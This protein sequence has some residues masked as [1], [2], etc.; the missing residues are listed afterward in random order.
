DFFY[1]EMG[2]GGEIL[3]SNVKISTSGDA[4]FRTPASPAAI[5]ANANSRAFFIWADS[6]TM[7]GNFELFFRTLQGIFQDSDGDGLPDAFEMAF[8]LNPN[9]PSDAQGDLDG[10][11]LTNLQEFRLQTD[12]RNRDTDG[13]GLSDGDEVN[14]ILVNGVLIKTDPL[15]PDMDSDGLSD[16]DEINVYRT[17]PLLADTDGDGLS[18]GIEVELGFNPNDST[19]L[20]KLFFTTDFDATGVSG[21]ALEVSRDTGLRPSNIY[22]SAPGKTNRLFT[23]PNGTPLTGDKLGIAAFEGSNIDAI[24][25]LPDGSF[26]FSIDFDATGVPGSAVEAR[27]ETGLRPADIYRSTG[28]GTNELFMSGDRLGIEPFEGSNI[29]GF[30]ILPDGS[31]LFTTDFGATG[32]PGSALEVARDTG[33]RPSNIYRSTGNGTHELF[34]SGARLG[35]VPFTGSNIDA[36]AVL[37]DMSILFSAD[38]DAE[39]V[40]GSALEVARETGLRPSNIYRSTGNGTN[41][42]FMSGDKLGIAPFTGSNVDG[43]GVPLFDRDGD[44]LSDLFERFWSPECVNRLNR[45]LDYT[46]ADSD[47][48]GIRDDLEDYDGDGLTNFQEFLRFTNPCNPDTDGDGISD[49]QEVALGTDPR[50][51]DTD[52]DGLSDGQEVNIFRTNPLLVDTD[53]DGVNDFLEARLDGTDPLNSSSNRRPIRITNILGDGGPSTRALISAPNGVAIDQARN[54]LYIADAGT[55]RIRRV[56]LTTGVITTLAGSG[57]EGFSGDCQPGDPPEKCPAT[58]ARLN[59]PL[60]IAVDRSGIVY[61]AD[62]DNNRIG[63]VNTTGALITVVGVTIPP[64]GIATI[65]GTGV[66][67]FSGDN[68]PARNAQLN[69]PTDVVV[70]GNGNILIA[71]AGNLRIRA[72]NTTTGPI[73]I[74]GVMIPS[75]AIATIAGNGTFGFAGDGGQATNASFKFHIRR[76]AVDSANNLYIADTANHLIRVVNTQTTSITVAGIT[77]ASGAIQTVAGNGVATFAGDG[78]SATSASLSSPFGVGVDGS[79]NIF[80][81]DSSSNR[82]RRVDSAGIITTVAGSS[83]SR[84]FAGDGGSATQAK[85]AFPVAVSL[86]GS[87]NLFILDN[88]NSRI[89]AVNRQATSST[90]AGVTV[91]P[92]AIQTVAGIGFFV[93]VDQPQVAIEPASDAHLIWRQTVGNNLQ[94]IF[95]SLVNDQGSILIPGTQITQAVRAISPAIVLGN[96]SGRANVVWQGRLSGDPQFDDEIFLTQV[97][98]ALTPIFGDPLPQ[99]PNPNVSEFSSIYP[100]IARD[101]SGNLHLIYREGNTIFYTKRDNRGVELVPPTVVVTGSSL[102]IA[103]HDIAVDSLGNVHIVWSDRPASSSFQEL[104]YKMLSNTGT[105]LIGI[106]QLTP[107]DNLDSEFPSIVIDMFGSSPSNLVSIVWEDLRNNDVPEIYL[108]QLNPLSNTISKDG[109]AADPAVLKTLPETALT[110]I[111]SRSSILPSAAIGPNGIIHVVWHEDFA[112]EGSSSDFATLHYLAA[113]VVSGAVR[114]LEPGLPLTDPGSVFVDPAFPR[115]FIS[116]DQQNTA[117][118]A[119]I[120]K[121]DE[122][123]RDIFL[124]FVK[125]TPSLPT[126]DQLQATQSTQYTYIPRFLVNRGGTPILALL[127]APAGMQ[128]VNGQIVWTPTNAQ[129]LA[130]SQAVA[131]QI[132]DGNGIMTAQT[133]TITVANVNDPPTVNPVGPFVVQ[134]GLAL[135]FTVTATDIDNEPAT[136]RVT[137][138]PPGATFTPQ[139]GVLSFTPTLG[140]LGRFVATFIANDGK[141]DGPP[142]NVTIDVVGAST[143]N[144]TVTANPTTGVIANGNATST[145]TVTARDAN[146]APIIGQ[147]VNLSVTGTSTI[148]GASS[149]RTDGNGMFFTTLASTRAETKTISAVVGT[150]PLTSTATVTFVAGPATTLTRVSGDNQRGTVGTALSQPLIVE[151]RDAQ[152]NLVPNFSVTF[153]PTPGSLASPTSTTTGATGQAQTTWTLA[154]FGGRQRLGVSGSGVHRVIFTATAAFLGITT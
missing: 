72:V 68:G 138:L 53:Q 111:D 57:F 26:L 70:D 154:R 141:V 117:A 116:V 59:S 33:L 27:R 32:V 62:S 66:S 78:G 135:T 84:G 85:L 12:P 123:T 102:P 152:G 103:G 81:A 18:D 63:A 34:I 99:T 90:V 122:P 58:R 82:I 19:T 144:S 67:G 9:D 127:S 89:R 41:E 50:N 22:E 55:N 100:R 80:I 21:S 45:P 77:I 150:V 143:A 47:G 69:F 134:E 49:G 97:D 24:V 11:G 76:I 79:G 121:S 39:G 56:D 29:D 112:Y 95:Y 6:G 4:S 5:V 36:I 60:G 125:P 148:L 107:S 133:F 83:N 37:P 2:P 146:N 96:A 145:I 74:A 106:T 87:G 51:P 128:I 119:W 88:N 14:G 71:D 10:D 1:T 142:T 91:A 131:L 109:N 8:G 105:T 28:N 42:L 38:F 3:L 31:I 17:N 104:F 120:G 52:G 113:R 153:I 147:V 151:A 98:K 13:D 110:A 94:Q 92:G 25:Q 43:I 140:Q 139:A 115:G 93:N 136:L 126:P 61:I 40:S 73:T 64:G 124:R 35:I 16:G 20:V 118:I 65:T 15:N 137:G 30:A 75:G 108:M 23:L 54:L 149:G 132:D 86:D 48:N 114:L 101:H 130:G 129:A 46:K 7:N 44:T